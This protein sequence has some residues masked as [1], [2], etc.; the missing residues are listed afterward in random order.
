MKLLHQPHKV[1]WICL[2]FGVL[3]LLING[4]FYQLYRMHR[5]Q[6]FLVDQIQATK[7]EVTQLDRLLKQAKDP[8]FIER[9]A[10]DNYD[11]AE[12]H[13]LIFVFSED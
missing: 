4:G 6:K 1:F 11:L 10:L 3:S 7:V 2:V 9:Q 5:D 8:S 13:D 12:E